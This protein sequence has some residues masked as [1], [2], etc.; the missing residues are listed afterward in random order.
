MKFKVDKSEELLNVI[1]RKM[2]YHTKTKARN[3]IKG[4]SVMVDGEVVSIPSTIVNE[5]QLVET[6]PKVKK[7]DK[8]EL[9]EVNVLFEDD[10]MVIAD[11]PVK[12]LSAKVK[13]EGSLS[14]TDEVD[15]YVKAKSANK[16]GAYPVNYLSKEMSGYMI[17]A[18]KKEDV[19]AIKNAWKQAYKSYYVV[20]EGNVKEELMTYSE[21]LKENEFGKMVKQDKKAKFARKAIIH[22]DL[23][24]NYKSPF[25]ALEIRPDT[26]VK[27]QERAILKSV[28]HPV[29]GD[30][31]YPGTSN[32]IKRLAM[33]NWKLKMSHPFKK[34]TVQVTDELP[35]RLLDFQ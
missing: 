13:R 11:K 31:E 25:A 29:V 7:R 6:G 19:E 35:K 23:L 32:R 2:G 5:G 27:D 8:A 14:F 21:M 33:H 3:F 26:Q 28:G 34:S 20:V 16:L 30:R 18:K 15:Q 4:G 1:I 17:F 12:K 9:A 24:K 10:Y 22:Q